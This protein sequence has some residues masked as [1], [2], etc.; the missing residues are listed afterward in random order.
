YL[1]NH[2]EVVYCFKPYHLNPFI[3]VIYFSIKEHR[4]LYYFKPL[5][6]YQKT[7]LLISVIIILKTESVKRYHAVVIPIVN[8]NLLFSPLI[9]LIFFW[10][11]QF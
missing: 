8:L 1:P 10:I 2:Q 4:I 7:T 11:K 6:Y 5:T 3:M 9:E